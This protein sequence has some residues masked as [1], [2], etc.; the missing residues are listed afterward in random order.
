MDRI[1]SLLNNGTWTFRFF[2]GS[3]GIVAY[4]LQALALYTIAKRRGL[5]KPWLAWVPVVN[6]WTLGAVSDHYQSV[7]N[8]QKKS[9]RKILLGLNIA[10]LVLEI[11]CLIVFLLVVSWYFS[12]AD[13]NLPMYYAAQ[14]ETGGEDMSYG[15][16]MLLGM[17][18]AGAGLLLV[19]LL[20]VLI[21]LVILAVFRWMAIYDVLKSCQPKD[22][23]T[24]FLV[25][26][27]VS[28][29]AVRGLESVF[30]LMCMNKD[31]GMVVPDPEPQAFDI[32]QEPCDS[33]SEM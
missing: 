18:A 8:G 24:Y 28:I 22:A 6:V 16:V 10:A 30:M 2:S 21:L 23:Q 11:I 20:P 15:L 12:G 19:C 32:P 17:L 25:S 9:K 14:P 13:T 5:N 26:L 27:L 31:E 4:V 3:L 29:F 7:V 1:F 33:D